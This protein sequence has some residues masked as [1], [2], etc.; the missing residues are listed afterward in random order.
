MTTYDL[1]RPWRRPF[2]TRH[3]LSSLS[4]ALG[5][6]CINGMPPEFFDQES[7]GAVSTKFDVWSFACCIVEMF[8]GRPPFYGKSM[9]VI[10]YKVASLRE[11]PGEAGALAAR[12]W[13]CAVQHTRA[14]ERIVMVF[15]AFDVDADVI[16][17]TGIPSELPASMQLLLQQCF[18]FNSIVLPTHLPRIRPRVEWTGVTSRARVSS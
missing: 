7:F 4:G 14:G 2:N 6:I 12:V 16:G 15:A 3:T 5:V 17:L 8:A 18:D 11:T 9:A 10:C 13:Q 1:L